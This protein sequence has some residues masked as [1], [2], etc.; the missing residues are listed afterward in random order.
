MVYPNM[1][2]L[3]SPFQSLSRMLD[4]Q[5]LDGLDGVPEHGHPPVTFPES[6]Q[7]VGSS[8]SGW[9]RWCTRTWASSGHLSR[10]SPECWIISIWMVSMVYP[11]MGIL[12]SPFQSLSRMLDHQHLD[13]L[14]GVP[15]H[16]HPPVTF[17]ESLQN[18]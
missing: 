15:E 18:V 8:A 10:V 13:G 3:R 9:S 2:I 7:N 14:D 5:H 17:P 12:R 4:H 11:N 16:G 1:G 6:L